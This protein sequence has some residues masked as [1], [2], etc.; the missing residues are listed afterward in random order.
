MEKIVVLTGRY[1]VDE[2]LI[3]C[4]RILFPDCEIQTLRR[5]SG[6]AQEIPSFAGKNTEPE[7]GKCVSL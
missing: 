5:E 3:E 1:G 2:K 4:L 7:S 6:D